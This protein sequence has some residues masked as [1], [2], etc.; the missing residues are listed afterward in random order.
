[1]SQKLVGIFGFPRSGTTWLGSILNSNPNVMYRFE[2]F[3]RSRKFQPR[4]Y[5]E[6]IDIVA[7]DNFSDQ[8]VS[9]LYDY[10]FTAC[11][12]WEIPP[13]FQKNYRCRSGQGRAIVWPLSRKQE[14]LKPLFSY[15]YT[16]LDN[17]TIVFKEVGH[18]NLYK[19]LLMKTDT[20]II[21]ILRN[22]CAVFKSQKKGNEENLMQNLNIEEMKSILNVKNKLKTNEAIF[23]LDKYQEKISSFSFAQL[24]ALRWLITVT[25]FL[26]SNEQKNLLLVIYEELVD[27]TEVMVEKIFAHSGLEVT[28]STA[29]FM[30]ESKAGG[31]I[32]SFLAKV[33]TGQIWTNSYFSVFRKPQSSRDSWKEKLSREEIEQ[34][35]EIVQDTKVYNMAVEAGYWQ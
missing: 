20:P 21:Y 33:K 18:K 25:E 12:D 24:F 2:P 34:I 27:K 35:L 19:Q 3:L 30:K 16:P 14:R 32:N 17:P 31:T 4:K 28:E 22:P 9:Q 23:Y 11:P 8:N 13:F 10:L 7:S 26:N 1:M 5:Q 29:N 15:L 6:I